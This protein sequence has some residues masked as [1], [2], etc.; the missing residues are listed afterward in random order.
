MQWKLRF[1][2]IVDVE[3]SDK[4]RVTVR[5]LAVVHV[6]VHVGVGDRGRR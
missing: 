3:C 2:G 6:D 4:R 5:I 1:G